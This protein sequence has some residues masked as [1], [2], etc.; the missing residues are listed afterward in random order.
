[1]VCTSLDTAISCYVE[2]ATELHSGIFTWA[3]AVFRGEVPFDQKV[4]ETF[5]SAVR[6]FLRRAKQ[7]AALGRGMNSECF[8]LEHLPALHHY[9]AHFD[10]LADNWKSPRRAIGPGARVKVPAA[11]SRLIL[12]RTRVLP[13]LDSDWSPINLEQGAQFEK[14]SMK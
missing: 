12:A 13:P 9:I 3:R 11:V 5:L 7:V 8:E 6:S 2:I 14:P 10:Y 4:E 1:M